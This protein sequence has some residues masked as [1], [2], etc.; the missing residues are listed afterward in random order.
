V[1]GETTIRRA[2]PRDLDFLVELANDDD[3]EPF[4]SARRARSPEDLLEEIERSQREPWWFG[5]F[6]VEVDGVRAGSMGFEVENRRSRVA[7][8][9]GLAI[10]PSFRG[11]R[12]ADDAARVLQRHLFRDLGYHRLQLEI[13]AFNERAIA[14]AERAGFVREGARRRA[15]WRHG[16]WVDGVLFGLVREDVD[17]ARSGIEVLFEHV[18]RF[19]DGVRTG[20]WAPM[21]EQFA[22]GA[23]MSF[24]GVP[25]GPFIGR[26]AIAAAYSEQP[27]DDEVEVLDAEER[28]GHLV[29]ARY[30]WAAEP[31]VAAGELR[32]CRADGHDRIA[33]LVVTF[34]RR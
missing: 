17:L 19:N 16:A 1:A 8:L 10:H 9:G 27:P 14:H 33:E 32:L 13:Y 31:G 3:V 30:A 26:E 29:V 18:V 20:D 25:L 6:V 22:D 2:E 28:D 5:R 4:L 34:E 7:A 24:E 11:R 12:L 21:L 15:Y 23:Q